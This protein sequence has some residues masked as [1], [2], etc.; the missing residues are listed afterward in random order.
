MFATY[1]LFPRDRHLHRPAR[2]TH[3]RLRGRRASG[4]DC[5]QVSWAARQTSATPVLITSDTQI[6]QLE[7]KGV[8]AEACDIDQAQ[9]P[10]HQGRQRFVEVTTEV[11][12]RGRLR[13]R[14]LVTV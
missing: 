4:S 14:P 9:L 11:G 1:A 13:R 10:D 6:D 2:E 7:K 5:S 12:P 8:L 3:G